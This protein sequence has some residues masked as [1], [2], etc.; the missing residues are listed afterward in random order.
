[1]KNKII[2][3]LL[4]VFILGYAH[5]AYA[6]EGLSGNSKVASVS[7]ATM[8][9]RVTIGA[10]GSG[11]SANINIGVKVKS[12]KEIRSANVVMQEFDYSCGSAALATLLGYLNDPVDEKEVIDTILKTGDI[13]KIIKR[14]GFSLL[15]LKRFAETRG[16]RAEGYGSDLNSMAALNHPVILPIIINN[17]KHFVVFLG[18]R[19]NR[20]YL[21]DPSKGITTMPLY[22]FE[23]VWFKNAFL[24]IT[25]GE[26][27]HPGMM[28][29]NVTYMDDIWNK[30][31]FNNVFIPRNPGR[32]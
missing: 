1:M 17:Y 2:A 11:L 28:Q 31:Q 6:A 16:F 29:I 15:D 20:V 9:L 22:Q 12:L 19:G 25:K 32:F 4:F 8:P 21:A 27:P 10:F 3:F 26:S 7:K 18:I 13:E 30:I 14:R 23:A 24:L 5:K